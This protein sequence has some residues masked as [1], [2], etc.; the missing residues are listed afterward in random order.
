LHLVGY[1][2]Y[3]TDRLYLLNRK[4]EGTYGRSEHIGKG[5]EFKAPAWIEP[6]VIQAV[7]GHFADFSK[8][9]LK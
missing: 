4:L 6:A 7:A 9:N 1:L 8:H 5:K 3:C 2:Y